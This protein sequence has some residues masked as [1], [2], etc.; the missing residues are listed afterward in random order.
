M[1]RKVL[2]EA[3]ETLESLLDE[4]KDQAQALI[5][6]LDENSGAVRGLCQLMRERRE[7]QPVAPTESKIDGEAATQWRSPKDYKLPKNF[8]PLLTPEETAKLEARHGTQLAEDYGPAW[9]ELPPSHGKRY[10]SLLD[11]FEGEK[12]MSDE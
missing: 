1:T 7:W 4:F 3:V 5:A 12:E 2:P 8:K 10:D 11:L 6:A 9:K